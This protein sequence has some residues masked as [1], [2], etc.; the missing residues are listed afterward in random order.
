MC[1]FL[2]ETSFLVKET[3]FLNLFN[4]LITFSGRKN[5]FSPS[6]KIWAEYLSTSVS[7]LFKKKKKVHS[8][9][10]ST[11]PRGNKMNM[12]KQQQNGLG[13]KKRFLHRERSGLVSTW[14]KVYLGDNIK[15]QLISHCEISA[16]LDFSCHRSIQEQI[17]F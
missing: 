12:S 4:L 6:K 16:C 2:F 8:V 13:W 3:H 11:V 17:K 14:S 5:V 9:S 10:P 15:P 7:H 1:T